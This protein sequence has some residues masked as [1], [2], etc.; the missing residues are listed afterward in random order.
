MFRIAY[1]VGTETGVTNDKQTQWAS[2][3][4]IAT[5]LPYLVAQSPRLFGLNTQGHAFIAVAAAISV[6]GLCG[7]CTYQVSEQ[8]LEPFL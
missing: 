7:Y 5:L 6:L 3:I 4:M 8:L 2:W 1:A